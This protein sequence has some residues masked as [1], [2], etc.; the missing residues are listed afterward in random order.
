MNGFSH[1]LLA[2]S[3]ALSDFGDGQVAARDEGTTELSGNTRI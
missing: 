2:H 1:D 3:D